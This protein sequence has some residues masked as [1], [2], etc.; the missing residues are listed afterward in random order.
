MNYKTVVI[1]V[2]IIMCPLL[3]KGQSF[4]ETRT[5]SKRVRANKDMTLE[6]SNKYGTIHITSWKTD[7]VYIRA[8]VEAFA[9]NES[10]LEKM[11][12]GISID[13]S[14]TNWFI[15]AKTEFTQSINMVVESFKGMTKK[16]IP[17]E[18]SVQINYFI[19]VPDYINLNIDNRYGDVY[20]E[21][22]NASSS[23]TVSNGSFKANSLNKAPDLTLTFCDAT[24]NK[25]TEGSIDASFSE[26]V[27]GESGS[28]KINS[29]SS[30]YDLKYNESINTE[31][32]RDKFFIGTTKSIKGTSYFTD[33]RIE[34][35]EDNLELETKYGSIN[36]DYIEKGINSIVINSGYTDINLVFDPLASY[37]LD[38]R[39]V[40]TFVSLPDKNTS[41]EKKSINEEKKEYLT[42]GTVGKSPGNIKVRIDATRGN[43]YMK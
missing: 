39:H 10:K 1:T 17:Y 36:A 28:L 3:L 37:N 24:I 15:R 5:F 6:V 20:M 29:I 27:I 40:N 26:I 12:D 30:R 34:K 19:D 42:F 23:I 35:L 2:L 7:S 33:F 13:I 16:L 4:S 41:L 22:N 25:I 9:S 11:L 31:S 14:E 43:I 32:K 38:I 8:E 21:S 18:S